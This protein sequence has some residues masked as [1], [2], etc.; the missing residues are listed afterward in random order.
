[1]KRMLP[2]LFFLLAYIKGYGQPLTLDQ[3]IN[4]V[5]MPSSKCDNYLNQKGFSVASSENQKDTSVR[6]YYFHG[7]KN[8]HDTITRNLVR[9]TTPNSN[10]IRFETASKSEFHEIAEKF[11]KEGFPRYDFNADEST[12]IMF[13]QKDLAIITAVHIE[14]EKLYTISIQKRLLPGIKEILYGE[15]LLAFDSHEHL[16]YVF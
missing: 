5:S 15:D 2:F 6:T 7:R 16:A 8:A 1:M 12:P 4:V 11:R 13:Q 3:L 9:R 14:E 10:Y